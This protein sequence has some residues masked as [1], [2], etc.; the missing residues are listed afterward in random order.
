M[1]ENSDIRGQHITVSVARD[2]TVTKTL[3]I[4]TNL[5]PW[6]TRLDQLVQDAQ[7]YMNTHD[8]IDRADIG[9]I[10]TPS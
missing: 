7:D 4:Q 1:I 9:C 5:Q 6:D 3:V 10:V 8:E 2:G